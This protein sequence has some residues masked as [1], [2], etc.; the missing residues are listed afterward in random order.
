MPQGLHAFTFDLFGLTRRQ[1]RDEEQV[2]L[3]PLDHSGRIRREKSDLELE[4]EE[5]C[6]MNFA[7]LGLYPVF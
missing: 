3:H 2:S 1:P 4:R 7:M 5:I 6:E